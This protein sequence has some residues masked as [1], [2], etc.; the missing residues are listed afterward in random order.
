MAGRCLFA[1]ILAREMALD[2]SNEKK[3]RLLA[4]RVSH[5]CFY[6][7]LFCE[8]DEVV[9]CFKNFHSRIDVSLSTLTRISTLIQIKRGLLVKNIVPVTDYSRFDLRANICVS[10]S[11]NYVNAKSEG[12]LHAQL[13]CWQDKSQ[14]AWPA[15]LVKSFFFLKVNILIKKWF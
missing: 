11:R 12:N 14:E 10:G 7:E 2:V 13:M 9:L 8:H 4:R 5:P 6:S 1:S 15:D 3:K